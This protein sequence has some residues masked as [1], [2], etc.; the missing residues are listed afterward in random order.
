MPLPDW[1][2]SLGPTTDSCNR[3]RLRTRG[4]AHAP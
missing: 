4:Q 2:C 1:L 3:S